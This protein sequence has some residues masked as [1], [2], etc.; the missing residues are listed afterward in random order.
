MQK[1][2]IMFQQYL[3]VHQMVK[4]VSGW[5][6]LYVRWYNVHI[7]HFIKLHPFML[8]KCKKVG[9]QSKKEK[10]K[11]FRKYS[12]RMALITRNKEW[13]IEKHCNRLPAKRWWF[14]ILKYFH[15][16]FLNFHFYTVHLFV[17]VRI[18]YMYGGDFIWMKLKILSVHNMISFEASERWER[19]SYSGLFIN[20][21][22]CESFCFIEMMMLKQCFQ[23]NFA[24]Q[25]PPS[26]L[27]MEILYAW[28]LN[29]IHAYLSLAI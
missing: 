3:Y 9:E 12:E 4:C 16:L 17:F 21:Y 24:Y 7:V 5:V 22:F 14:W 8:H 29:Y 26:P 10:R 2:K 13:E 20:L 27:N 23:W 15:F 1:V 25:L 6:M 11:T 28:T 18:R 19:S